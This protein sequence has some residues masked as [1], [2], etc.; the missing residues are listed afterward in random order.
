[1]NTL[2]V[3]I[4]LCNHGILDDVHKIKKLTKKEMDRNGGSSRKVEN[5]A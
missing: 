2:Y 5:S 3:S 1:V 4:H